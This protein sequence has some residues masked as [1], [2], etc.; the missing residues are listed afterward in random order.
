M[1]H[2]YLPTENHLSLKK[3]YLAHCFSV[4][5]ELVFERN[6]SCKS[7]FNGEESL[8]FFQRPIHLCWRETCVSR[9]EV[10]LL[11]AGA[12]M[13]CFPVRMVVILA[14]V[15]PVTLVFQCE[16]R[17]SLIQIG[18]FSSGKQKNLPIQR[19]ACMLEHAASHIL[20]SCVNWGSLG[21]EHFLQNRF[22]GGEEMIVFQIGL[23]SWVDE[24]H[25]FLKENHVH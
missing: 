16:Y 2:K 17:L 24:T 10:F 15:L 3:E 1:K 23:F 22:Q 19:K 6:T 4:K 9:T 11:D 5:T 12:T 25:A 13:H 8:T 14:K 21:E 20:F 7:E 18:Q